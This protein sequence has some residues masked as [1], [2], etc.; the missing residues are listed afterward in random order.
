MA[1]WESLICSKI[2][3]PRDTHTVCKIEDASERNKRQPPPEG[4][5][6]NQPM[7]N[8]FGYPILDNPFLYH[9]S[10]CLNRVNF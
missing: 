6:F 4:Q 1:N 2:E 9:A 5:A 8:R 10:A 7:T 3:A